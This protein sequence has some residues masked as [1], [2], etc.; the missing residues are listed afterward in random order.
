MEDSTYT[1]ERLTEEWR[2]LIER[3]IAADVPRTAVVETMFE[4]SL[5][6]Y[7]EL[8][9]DEL[10][11]NYLRDVLLQLETPITEREIAEQL[12]VGESAR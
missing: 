3:S 7:R 6:H 8:Y 11:G 12:I 5:T 10:A 2:R 1:R 9:G 4:V